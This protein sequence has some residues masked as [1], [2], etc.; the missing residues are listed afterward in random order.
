MLD[1]GPPRLPFSDKDHQNPD[2]DFKDGEFQRSPADE[3][4]FSED[5]S[6][7]PETDIDDESLSGKESPLQRENYSNHDT[8]IKKSKR[9]RGR[10]RKQPSESESQDRATSS[11]IVSFSSTTSNAAISAE[12]FCT[13][14]I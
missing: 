6:L 10:P 12:N 7:I 1:E 3:D 11:I 4:T 9:T 8:E 5:P 13:G 14:T 2:T